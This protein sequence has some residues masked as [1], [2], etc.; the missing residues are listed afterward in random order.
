MAIPAKKLSVAD[1]EHLLN[2]KKSHLES[3][4]KRRTKLQQ[5]LAVVEKEIAGL[6]GGRRGK[7]GGKRVVRKRRKNKTSLRAVI[8][9]V[10][11]A[12]KKG[13]ALADVE[14]KVLESGYKS[15]SNKFRNVIY[16]CLY[17]NKEFVHDKKAGLYKVKA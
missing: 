4:H 10:L 8:S 14:A 11:T 15:T 2:T 12:N 3:L 6:E 1:L 16:Q 7:R 5:E 9:N 17:N 13:L